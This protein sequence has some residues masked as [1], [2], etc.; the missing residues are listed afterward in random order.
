MS[1]RFRHGLVVGKFYPP[2]AGHH[3]LVEAAAA[4]CAAVTVV[5][6]PSRRESI[7]LDLRLDWLREAHASTPWVRFVGRYD[8][9]PVD[10]ADPAVWD[11]HC[12]V[13]ADALAGAPVDAVFSSEAYGEELARRFGAVAVDVDPDRRAV[14]VSGT[15]VRADPAAHWRWLSPPVRAWLVRRVVVVGAESTGTTTM[16]RG[17]AEHYR[18]A[19][20]PEFGRELTARKLAG[21]RRSRPDATVFDVTW[22]RYDFVEVVRE[23]QAAED[24]AARVSG[25]LLFCDTD[26]RATAVWEERYLGSSSD[27][28]RAAAR[29]PALYLLT[30]HEGVPFADD[31]LRDGEHLRAWMTGRFRAELAGCGVP[32]VGLRG[33]HEERLA[34][35]TAACDALLAAGWCFTDPVLPAAG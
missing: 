23:Q 25:P 19:W 33:T 34:A 18:T 20:V 35:A 14:P 7:P 5:V 6:A 4:R 26:A 31:G 1:G 30:D 21:L 13:F 32:V 16:A 27:A 8:D 17:L 22:D 12:A 24:A 11:L 10:Y 28:V 2:H 29:R 3:A 9:H 15:A